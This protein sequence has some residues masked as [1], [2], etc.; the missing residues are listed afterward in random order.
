MSNIPSKILRSLASKTLKWHT[1]DQ[2]GYFVC[3]EESG[4]R[5]YLTPADLYRIDPRLPHSLQWYASRHDAQATGDLLQK[6]MRYWLAP[7]HLPWSAP[8]LTSSFCLLSE[9]IAIEH[10]SPSTKYFKLR[11]LGLGLRHCQSH[12]IAFEYAKAT[13]SYSVDTLKLH[14][15]GFEQRLDSVTGL[16][17]AQWRNH[18][19]GA[20]SHT[21]TSLVLSDDIA[22]AYDGLLF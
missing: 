7:F 12:K 17:L 22:A 13:V 11:G 21:T 8:G 15:P 3:E 4:K 19:F 16:P 2:P 5:T 14:V 9:I 6:T 10:Y 20:H 18:L 1:T